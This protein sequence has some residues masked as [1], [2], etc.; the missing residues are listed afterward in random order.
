MLRFD[1]DLED[2]VVEIVH[3]GGRVQTF[4]HSGEG[5]VVLDADVHAP[6]P[7]ANYPARSDSCDLTRSPTNEDVSSLIIVD[8]PDMPVVA[9]SRAPAKALDL[10]ALLAPRSS[11]RRRPS[12]PRD[13]NTAG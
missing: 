8:E 13:C 3:P 1:Y 4:G 11:R 2:R 7:T 5:D 9:A 12:S 6:P 10:D